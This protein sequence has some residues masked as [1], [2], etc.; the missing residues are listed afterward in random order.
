[1]MKLYHNNTRSLTSLLRWPQ[2]VDLVCYKTLILLSGLCNLVVAFNR[3]STPNTLL[4]K[5]DKIRVLH[6]T[7]EIIDLN[8]FS[9]LPFLNLG[10]GQWR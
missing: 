7:L 2:E 3:I 10:R 5:K 4:G 8:N 9:V 6:K 1:M